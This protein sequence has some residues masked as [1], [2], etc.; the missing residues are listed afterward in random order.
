MVV[1]KVLSGQVKLPGKDAMRAEYN[2]KVKTKGYGK[3]FHSLRDQEAAYVNELIAW[4]NSDLEKAGKGRL[5]GH[6]EK[7]HAA[8]AEQLERMKALFS[9]PSIER[10]VEVTCL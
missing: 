9:T 6:T 10:R 2:D 5:Y 4:V 1:A 8:R 7:W 3:A